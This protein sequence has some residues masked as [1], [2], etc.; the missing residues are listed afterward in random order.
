MSCRLDI[1]T[2]VRGRRS[3]GPGAT[4]VKLAGFDFSHQRDS[5]APDSPQ[6]GENT[7]PQAT[8]ARI[9]VETILRLEDEGETDR[10]IAARMSETVGHFAGTISFVLVQLC[11]IGLW[12]RRSRP[13]TSELLRSRR[14]SAGACRLRVSATN[15][16]QLGSAVPLV[17]PRVQ[18]GDGRREA[19]RPLGLGSS[20]LLQLRDRRRVSRR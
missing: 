6:P 10:S 17:L 3:V 7:V 5:S 11:L 19:S 12:V 8:T 16:S 20:P 14:R 13:G 18:H 2:G 1:T 9:N 4:G 15:E